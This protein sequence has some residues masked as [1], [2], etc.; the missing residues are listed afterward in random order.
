MDLNYL[1]KLIK[2]FEESSLSDLKIDEEGIK[3]EMSN[4]GRFPGQQIMQMAAPVHQPASQHVTEVPHTHIA[5]V[6]SAEAAPGD[7]TDAFHKISSPIVGTFYRAPSPDAPSFVEVGTRVSVGTPLCII[8]AMKLM[9]EIESDISGTI[10]KIY[11]Q[12]AQPVE[13]NQPLFLIKPD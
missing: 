11:L 1:K 3:I 8:E 13:F 4:A 2:V 12:N 10:E 7:G 9:N 5:P 6:I